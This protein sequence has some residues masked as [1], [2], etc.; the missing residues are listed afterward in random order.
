MPAGSRS[1]STIPTSA[2]VSSEATKPPT[3]TTPLAR[4]EASSGVNVRARSNPIMDAGPPDAVRQTSTTSSHSGDGSDRASTA[5]HA[6]TIPATT[7][8]TIT[9]R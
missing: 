9:E 6:I 8:S 3:L 1:W 5:V 4:P 7:L 2:I